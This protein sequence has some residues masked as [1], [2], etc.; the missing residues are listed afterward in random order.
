MTV[1][2]SANT[3]VYRG[4]G[5]AT[6]F[7]VPFKVLDEEHLVV[8]KRDYDSGEIVS[9]YIGT[10]YSYSGIGDSEGTLTLAGAALSSDYELVIERIVPYTQDLDIVNSG[11]FYPETVE[12]QLDLI[13]MGLQQLANGVSRSLKVAVGDTGVEL[14][15]AT[16]KYLIL[17]EVGEL[18][19]TATALALVEFLQSGSG[20]VSRSA[21]SKIREFGFSVVDFGAAGDG[22]TD[23]TEAFIDCAAAIE[24]AG[25]GRMII[26]PG[27][28]VVGT[29][30]FAGATGLGYAYTTETV[31]SITDCTEL[32]EIIGYGAKLIAPDGLK[33]GAFNP[34]T[35]EAAGD[36]SS[37]ND[38]RAYGITFISLIDN[39]GG[40]IIR[41]LEIDGNLPGYD[42]GGT[43]HAPGDTGTQLS[44]YGIQ[45]YGNSS[46]FIDNC[47][48][49]H[50]PL[51]N[52]AIGWTGMTVLTPRKPHTLL[53]S[54]FEYGGRQALSL[55]GC[56]SL[57][58]MNCSFS[59]TGR[60]SISS[61]PGAGVDFE[62]ESAV[63]RNA[64]FIDC[65]MSNNTGLGI[66]ADSGDTAGATFIRCR[67]IGTTYWTIWTRMPRFHFID[68]QMY[69]QST[70]PYSSL[71]AGEATRF[72]NCHFSFD[73]T[74]SPLEV[75]G[76]KVLYNSTAHLFD[77]G[78]GAL[79]V[80][81]E[82]CS[83]DTNG[84]GLLITVAT[85]D[86]IFRNCTF[87][88]T[89]FG[90]NSMNAM[91]EGTTR[92][93]TGGGSLNLGINAIRGRFIFNGVESNL[94]PTAP[95][96]TDLATVI[97]LANS[98]KTALD[99]LKITG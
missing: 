99:A 7:A 2:T 35:G 27:I 87:L 9:T 88:Q 28:Y 60:S 96:A 58:A 76:V 26:P 72:T 82:S 3:V 67:V 54:R 56:N 29:Q 25:G 37:S 86:C 33:Y 62:A 13:T 49:H 14:P 22:V 64:V 38:E 4:N 53:N 30:T 89:N 69:G 90:V 43:W 18:D 19:T 12:E 79:G 50:N 85:Q 48:V 34:S 94:Y 92:V 21:Q 68:C 24:A 55:V 93:T 81:F 20:A 61:S 46:V 78:G 17:N 41:G 65:E 42:I 51:D 98:L 80:V 74:Q 40:V 15:N 57:L 5:S 75:A 45:V 36:D 83:F 1:T 31:V 47:H 71:V 10:D 95:V 63:I 52:I 16:N 6:S 70:N 73:I 39:A 23:D 11:G 91:F 66:V 97:T 32:V 77:L 84:T 8:R 44:G 59:H